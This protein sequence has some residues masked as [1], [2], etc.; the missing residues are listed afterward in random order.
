MEKKRLTE[1]EVVME[2]TR[3]T[4]LD[5]DDFQRMMPVFRS[6]AGALLLK[7]LIPL[8]GIDKIN[9]LYAHSCDKEGVEFI[10][11][12]LDELQVTYTVDHA[13]RL[14]QLPE[15]AFITVSNHPFGALDGILLIR[16]IAAERPDFKVMVNW[17]LEYIATMSEHFIGVNPT[18]EKNNPS[19]MNGLKN[20]IRHIREGHPLGFFPA[21]S[22]SKLNY[23][24]R[25]VDREWQPNVLR[26]IR[27]MKVPVVP[28]YFHGHNSIF[29]HLLGLIHW[30]IRSLRLPREVFNKNDKPIRIGIGETIPV[31]E[32]IRH[33]DLKDLGVFLKSRTYLMAK[34]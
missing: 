25:I 20:S 29:Y 8:V 10:N 18:A 23:K 15:G 1:L 4:V 21:G 5:F 30:Q 14:R 9:A 26:L 19:S 28:V 11:S 6:R 33:N 27:Q 34:E 22:V 32:L 31:E 12:L 2:I 13:E 17:I 7:V 3:K 24:L 16:L